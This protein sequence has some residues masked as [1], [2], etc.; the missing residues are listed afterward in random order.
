MRDTNDFESDGQIQLEEEM[1]RIIMLAENFDAA[2][3]QNGL[4]NLR[5]NFSLVHKKKQKKT[6]SSCTGEVPLLLHK[7]PRLS[8]LAARA[9]L[10]AAVTPL[11]QA[12]QVILFESSQE[13]SAHSARCKV[14]TSCMVGKLVNRC[15]CEL[16][17]KTD[18]ELII[19]IPIY[20]DLPIKNAINLTIDIPIFEI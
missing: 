6:Q 14:C 7:R 3:R 15:V 9:A 5:R 18:V 20:E 11:R 1:D 17:E 12:R 8:P 10:A 2:R 19:D 13:L 16:M 4:Q